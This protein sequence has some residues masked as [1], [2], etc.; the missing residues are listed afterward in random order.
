M[1]L[2]ITGRGRVASRS[3]VQSGAGPRRQG[4]PF[5]GVGWPDGRW[6]D[7]QSLSGGCPGTMCS[8]GTSQMT[9]DLSPL[10]PAQ[11]MLEQLLTLADQLGAVTAEAHQKISEACAEAYARLDS[12]PDDVLTDAALAYMDAWTRAVLAV[13]DGHEQLTATCGLD[14]LKRIGAAQAKLVRTVVAASAT[15]VR[16]LAS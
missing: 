6:T 13:A 1:L 9:A 3:P 8:A 2:K 16:N 4:A 14:L 11:E 15:T 10:T 5:P 7:Y 12:H